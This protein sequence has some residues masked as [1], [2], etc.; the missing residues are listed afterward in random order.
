MIYC[1]LN[2]T[3]IFDK[4]ESSHSIKKIGYHPSTELSKFQQVPI[5]IINLSYDMICKLI[6][7]QHLLNW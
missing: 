2:Q 1:N 3:E 7:S 6:L 5:F 4:N